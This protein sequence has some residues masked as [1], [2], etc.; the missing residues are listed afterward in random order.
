M[1]GVAYGWKYENM[2]DYKDA[3]GTPGTKEKYWKTL[4]MNYEKCRGDSFTMV[5]KWVPSSNVPTPRTNLLTVA[6]NGERYAESGFTHDKFYKTD[7]PDS[8]RRDGHLYLQSHW[9][10]GV[11]FQSATLVWL[12]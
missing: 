11:I 10:S 3:S 9:G 2:Q 4:E 8:S 5:I 12:S 6:L 7:G 1:H